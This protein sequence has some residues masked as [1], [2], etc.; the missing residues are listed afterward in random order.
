MKAKE[1]DVSYEGGMTD[2]SRE[3]MKSGWQVSAAKPESHSATT[4]STIQRTRSNKTEAQVTEAQ[5]HLPF[6]VCSSTKLITTMQVINE[7]KCLGNK[8]LID[9]YRHLLQNEKKK[10]E[11]PKRSDWCAKD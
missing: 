5:S 1:K 11:K 2:W 6:R 10:A 7:W 3:A 8:K 9:T 4:D